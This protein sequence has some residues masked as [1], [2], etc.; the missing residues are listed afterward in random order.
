VEQVL[1]CTPDKDLAQCVVGTRVVQ[2]DRRR[3]I[4]R[5]EAGV[6]LKWGYSRSRFRV[7]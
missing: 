2:F 7:T 6:V 3:S 4:M 5:D 1:I